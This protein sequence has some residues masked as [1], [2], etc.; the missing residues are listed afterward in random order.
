MMIPI[1][2]V[3]PTIKLEQFIPR[4]SAVLSQ[5]R[6]LDPVAERLVT[7]QPSWHFPGTFVPR[8][9]IVTPVVTTI[10]VAISVATIRTAAIGF[11]ILVSV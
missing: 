10:M 4:Q 7:L 11:G 8:A 3:F 5:P 1:V 2:R 6:V 9:V